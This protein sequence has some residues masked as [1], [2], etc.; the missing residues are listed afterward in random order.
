MVSLFLVDDNQ[1]VFNISNPSSLAGEKLCDSSLHLFP[2]HAS[3]PFH[4]FVFQQLW[5]TLHKQISYLLSFLI[6]PRLSLAFCVPVPLRGLSPP[7]SS[8]LSPSL[9]LSLG[10]LQ[11]SLEVDLSIHYPTLEPQ[12]LKAFKTCFAR[13]HFIL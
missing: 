6:L 2:G 7:Q 9:S 3:I 13:G 12:E 8:V 1:R 5:S 11:V 4:L 10:R